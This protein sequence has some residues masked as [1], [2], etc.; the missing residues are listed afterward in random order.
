MRIDKDT[1]TIATCII[2]KQL[3][4]FK[5]PFVFDLEYKDNGRI[6][7]E[8]KDILELNTNADSLMELRISIGDAIGLIWADY[9]NCPISQLTKDAI[10]FRNKLK[11]RVVE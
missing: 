7:A 2:N 9:V 8:C 1:M 5:P 11:E 4:I 10:E 3:V 6:I